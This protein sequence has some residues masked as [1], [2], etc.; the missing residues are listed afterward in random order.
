MFIVILE[1]LCVLLYSEGESLNE[2]VEAWSSVLYLSP[3]NLGQFVWSVK[4]VGVSGLSLHKRVGTRREEHL[5]QYQE[6]FFKC[7]VIQNETV[8]LKGFA[9]VADRS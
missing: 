1:E 4:T 9:R 6:K 8:F 7:D 2:G 5:E 3:D